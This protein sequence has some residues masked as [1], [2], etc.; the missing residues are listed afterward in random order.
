MTFRL[1]M[2]ILSY[3]DLIVVG[4]LVFQD[5]ALAPESIFKKK[6]ESA[7]PNMMD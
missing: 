1:R 2:R 6:N 5:F 4:A 3:L 7:A